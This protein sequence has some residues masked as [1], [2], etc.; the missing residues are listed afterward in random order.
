MQMVG[1]EPTCSCLRQI[2]S[3]LRLPFRHICI[4]HKEGPIEDG[5]IPYDAAT[6]AKRMLVWAILM[7]DTPTGD[8]RKAD[9]GL[10]E[11]P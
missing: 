11:R 8:I 9:V 7:R 4:C 3:L 10:G 1:L 2:L 5:R 6:S